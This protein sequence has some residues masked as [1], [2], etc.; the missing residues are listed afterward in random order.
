MSTITTNT[1]FEQRQR[2]IVRFLM[3]LLSVFLG[4]LIGKGGLMVGMALLAL[5]V[6]L[7]FIGY[8][9]QNTYANLVVA[10]AVGFFSAGI[11]RY[12]AASWGLLVDIFLFIGLLSLIFKKTKVNWKHLNNDIMYVTYAWFGLVIL[13]IVNPESNGFECWFYAMRGDGF[14]QLLCFALVFMIAQD[15]KYMD[16]L[17]VIN[18]VFSMLGTLWGLR[19]FIFGVDEAEHRWLYVEGYAFTHVLH[20]VLRVFSFYSDAG[21]FGASQAMFALMCGIIAQGPISKGARIFYILG[22]ILNFVG[23]GIS[24]TRGAVAVPAIGILVYLF[25]S[26]N[27]KILIMGLLVAGGAFYFLKYTKGLQH[28]EQVRRMRTAFDPNDASLLVRLKNQKTFG[29][30]LASRPFGGGIGAAGFWGYRYAPHSLLGNTATDSYYVKIWAETGIIGL[31][32][33]L[34]M[35]GYFVGKGGYVVY[36]IRDPALRFKAAGIFSAMCGVFM[37]SYGNQVYSQMPTGIVLGV[38]IPLIFLAPKYDDQID[39]ERASANGK[40]SL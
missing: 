23:F 21:Q 38:L 12:V 11:G 7:L 18:C 25:L 32:L 22:A 3:V 4:W 10:L 34:F 28:V 20:G 6:G 19:Q 16:K 15:R 40:I 35:F 27:H 5:P 26:R 37:A 13:E 14:Y 36:N 33:H 1:D 29:R 2:N 31:S 8:V 39:E 30:Y 17:L 9:F 24:G